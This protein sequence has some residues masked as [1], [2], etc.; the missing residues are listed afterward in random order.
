MPS[1]LDEVVRNIVERGN[2]LH[3]I[4]EFIKQ[5]SEPLDQRWERMWND[6]ELQLNALE[7][8]LSD[9]ERNTRRGREDE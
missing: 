5:P 2:A 9:L 7:R 6:L 3:G 8:E 4:S 1:D